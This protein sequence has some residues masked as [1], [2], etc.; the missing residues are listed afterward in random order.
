MQS[1]NLMKKTSKRRRSFRKDY[2][3]VSSDAKIVKKLLGRG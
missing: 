3:L 2:V 1:H